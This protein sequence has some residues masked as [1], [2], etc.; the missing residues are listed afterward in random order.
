MIGLQPHALGRDKVIS[1]GPAP[2]TLHVQGGA[3]AGRGN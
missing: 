1:L 2:P 3:F